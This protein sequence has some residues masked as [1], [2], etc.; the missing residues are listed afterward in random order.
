MFYKKWFHKT[1]AKL[2]GKYLYQ[3]LFLVKLQAW[4]LQLY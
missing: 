2:T 3:S 4:G 1:F